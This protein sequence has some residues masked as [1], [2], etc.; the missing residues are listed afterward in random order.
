MNET[1]DDTQAASAT[2][3][4]PTPTSSSSVS[5]TKKA[6]V[7]TASKKTAKPGI[8]AR[9]KAKSKTKT[10]TKKAAVSSQAQTAGAIDLPFNKMNKAEQKI[11]AA[12]FTK[13]GERKPF[14]IKDIMKATGLKSSPVR[15][16]VRRPVRGRWLEHTIVKTDDG[17]KKRGVYR[18]T[19][20][21]RKRGLKG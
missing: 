16:N 7:K 11:V 3:T 5:K 10:K 21:A 14:T 4:T 9:L 8:V 1:K 15:N 18:L 13:A 19:E 6:A 17:S 12:V 20:A 2:D